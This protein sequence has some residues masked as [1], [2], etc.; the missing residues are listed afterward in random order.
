MSLPEVG[1]KG[2]K[3]IMKVIDPNSVCSNCTWSLE[4]ISRSATIPIQFDKG[5]SSMLAAE[6]MGQ[7]AQTVTVTGLLIGLS[8]NL[9]LG[10][11]L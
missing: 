9:V 1:R 5:S 10:G 4:I 3:L 7:A 6:Q 11:G 2:E 8:I